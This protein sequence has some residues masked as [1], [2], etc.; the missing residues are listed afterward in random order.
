METE[1]SLTDYCEAILN[2]VMD[3]IEDIIIIHDSAYTIVWMNNSGL[4]AFNLKI[5]DVI[6]KHCHSL[7]GYRTPCTDCLMP[8]VITHG[9]IEKCERSIPSLG[10]S[11]NCTSNPVRDENGQIAMV[12]QYLHKKK[13]SRVMDNSGEMPR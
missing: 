10:E 4:K 9:S 7:F 6:G 5:E 8:R 3:V 1:K 11:Y 13:P 2:I 12:V